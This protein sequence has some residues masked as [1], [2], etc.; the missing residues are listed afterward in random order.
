MSA[1]FIL[2]TGLGLA[3]IVL[4]LLVL[5]DTRKDTPKEKTIEEIIKAILE[6][7]RK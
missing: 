5:R 2:L 1:Q 7:D 4:V 3:F 6:E